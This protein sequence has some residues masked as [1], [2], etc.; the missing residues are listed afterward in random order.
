MIFA[1][2]QAAPHPRREISRLIPNGASPQPDEACRSHLSCGG[3]GRAG[4]PVTALPV[5]LYDCRVAVVG[6]SAA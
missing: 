6:L 5:R 4:S 1:A 2:C 3:S